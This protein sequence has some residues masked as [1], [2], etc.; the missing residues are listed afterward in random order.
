M[1][2]A[3]KSSVQK[4]YDMIGKSSEGEETLALQGQHP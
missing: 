2:D 1:V 3:T 4:A